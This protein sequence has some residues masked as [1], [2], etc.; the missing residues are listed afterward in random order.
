MFL[1]TSWNIFYHGCQKINFKLDL[2]LYFDV[3]ICLSLCHFGVGICLLLFSFTLRYFFPGSWYDGIYFNWNLD[4]S[5]LCLR[6]WIL[7]NS[8]LLAIF[9]HRGYH[10]ITARWM[11]KVRLPIQPLLTSEREKREAQLMLREGR[12]PRKMTCIHRQWRDSFQHNC[13]HHCQVQQVNLFEILFIRVTNLGLIYVQIF[14]FW[15]SLIGAYINLI[16][17]ISCHMF[18]I[19]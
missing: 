12:E 4:I 13:F 3:G 18:F 6:F 17:V 7:F 19:V 15:F 5:V 1:I 16:I 14:L 8:S 10:I 2:K 11:Y 9:F